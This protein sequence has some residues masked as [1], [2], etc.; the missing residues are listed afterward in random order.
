VQAHS[1]TPPPAVSRVA[2]KKKAV[3]VSS[4]VITAVVVVVVLLVAIALGIAGCVYLVRR[5]RRMERV[6]NSPARL[7]G[8]PI[9]GYVS[10]GGGGNGIGEWADVPLPGYSRG[11]GAEEVAV[12]K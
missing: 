8:F 9:V 3:G 1:L 10:S 5:R 12:W 6:R 4:K 11:A 2:A 7:R